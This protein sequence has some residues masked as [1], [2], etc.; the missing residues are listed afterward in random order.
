MLD[1]AANSKLMSDLVYRTKQVANDAIDASFDFV[2]RE[3][4]IGMTFCRLSAFAACQSERARA[5]STALR[6]LLAAEVWTARLNFRDDRQRLLVEQS[7]RLKALI[8]KALV[9]CGTDPQQFG[10]STQREH[11]Q[12]SD[13]A[14]AA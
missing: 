9:T 12:S 11:P 14:A 13:T 3:L 1:D 2:I 10:G 7:E 5:I 4:Q 8:D 6:H